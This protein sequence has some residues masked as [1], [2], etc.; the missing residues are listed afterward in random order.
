M[1]SQ[2][3]PNRSV[4]ALSYLKREDGSWNLLVIA[5]GALGVVFVGLLIL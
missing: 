1:T 4:D 5:G 2:H 3:E